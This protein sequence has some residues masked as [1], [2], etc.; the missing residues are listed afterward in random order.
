MGIGMQGES[1]DSDFP[2]HH[3]DYHVGSHHLLTHSHTKQQWRRQPV[4]TEVIAASTIK[5]SSLLVHRVQDSGL[6][7]EQTDGRMSSWDSSRTTSSIWCG[8][9]FSH[10]EWYQR[11]IEADMSEETFAFF[12]FEAFWTFEDN[13]TPSSAQGP[14]ASIC[15]HGNHDILYSCFKVYL[16]NIRRT[17]W[18]QATPQGPQPAFYSPM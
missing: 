5:R 17:P 9:M 4:A 2:H 8:R 13:A 3:V 6:W 12:Q 10:R 14:N 15:R 7:F 11:V 18:V 16:Q 1:I